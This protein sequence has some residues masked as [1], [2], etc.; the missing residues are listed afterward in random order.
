MEE[1][2]QASKEEGLSL[3]SQIAQIKKVSQ[4]GDDGGSTNTCI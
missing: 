1:S 3:K 4:G 2:L